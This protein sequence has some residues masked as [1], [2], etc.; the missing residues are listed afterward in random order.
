MLQWLY[1]TLQG[2]VHGDPTYLEDKSYY[3]I[4]RR[5][6]VHYT[7]DDEHQYGEVEVAILYRFNIRLTQLADDPIALTFTRYAMAW[8]DVWDNKL[9]IG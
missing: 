5:R 9:G 3:Y 8:S 7:W 1:D 2:Y 4:A 6:R